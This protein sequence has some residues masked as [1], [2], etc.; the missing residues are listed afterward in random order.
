MNEIYEFYEF[1]EINAFYAINAVQFWMDGLLDAQFFDIL[2][3]RLRTLRRAK[4]VSGQG[5]PKSREIWTVLRV[6]YC[7]TAL[8]RP[9][10][11]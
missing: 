10:R 6:A 5:R 2:G 4:V 3:V 1:Y 11:K 8:S 9:A 7:V